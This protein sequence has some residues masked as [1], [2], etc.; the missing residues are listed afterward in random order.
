MRKHIVDLALSGNNIQAE[1]Q[2]MSDVPLV[3]PKNVHIQKLLRALINPE[4]FY[5][6]SVTAF[7]PP[8]LSACL[9]QTRK[10]NHLKTKIRKV[11]NSEH[12][13]QSL[14]LHKRNC[15]VVWCKY[16]FTSP[17]PTRL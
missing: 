17:S 9:P 12:H 8:K 15:T 11:K 7:L 4:L 6:F 2:Q 16:L 13:L 1:E 10:I 5:R 3:I 14:A